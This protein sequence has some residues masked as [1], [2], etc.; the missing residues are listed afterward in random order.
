MS[1]L[2]KLLGDS[3]EHE[4]IETVPKRGYR[5]TAEVRRLI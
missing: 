5:F 1:V 4:Y 3:A 2:R